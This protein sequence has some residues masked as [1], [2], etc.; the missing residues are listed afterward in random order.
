MAIYK[1]E[2]SEIRFGEISFTLINA[3]PDLHW[4]ERKTAKKLIEQQLYDVFCKYVSD[5]I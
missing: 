1:I 5:K 3:V 4:E 2:S